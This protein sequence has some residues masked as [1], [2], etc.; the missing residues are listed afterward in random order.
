MRGLPAP[1]LTGLQKQLC[2]VCSVAATRAL[3]RLRCLALGKDAKHPPSAW[4]GD[5]E[6][7]AIVE[8][9]MRK[10]SR[11]RRRVAHNGK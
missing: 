7:F 5:A 2:K 10:N 9:T 1:R 8:A 4:D 3:G 6:K 11:P